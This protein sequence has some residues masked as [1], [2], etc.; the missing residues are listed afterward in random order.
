MAHNFITFVEGIPIFFIGVTV[1]F[2]M[3]LLLIEFMVI[4]G[5]IMDRVTQKNNKVALEVSQTVEEVTSTI[6][7]EV[8]DD[9]ELI[10]VITSAIAA[11][12]ET[13]SDKLQVRSLKK[14]QR[15]AL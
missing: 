10:A 13:T 12:L 15:K 6:E 9:L 14:V 1:V 4:L 7:T 8:Q 2:G 3:L 11:S 5:K